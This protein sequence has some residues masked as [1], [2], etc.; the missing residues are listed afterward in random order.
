MNRIH[1]HAPFLLSLLWLGGAALAAEPKFKTAIVTAAWSYERPRA[2][3]DIGG[4]TA[5]TAKI[6]TSSVTIALDGMLVTGEWTP[7]MPEDPS[8]DDFRSG[9][10][11]PAS[12]STSRMVLK[13]PDGTEVK[14]KVVY[15]EKQKKPATTR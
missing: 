2:S 8:S 6:L 15:R 9:T 4:I 3:I 10:E 1:R 7:K 12:V 13:L 11:V 5:G 14:A